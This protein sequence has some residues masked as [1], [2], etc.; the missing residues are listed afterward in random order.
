[1]TRSHVYLPY[2]EFVEAD[3]V[4]VPYRIWNSLEEDLPTSG[5]VNLLRRE[6]WVPLEWGGRAVT[7]HELAHVAWS[8]ARSA[9]VRFDHRVLAAMEDAR[10]N[11]GLAGIG[12]PVALDAESHAHVMMLLAQ[13][14]KR[15]DGFALFMRSIASLGTSVEAGLESQ[16]L[17]MPGPLGALVVAWMARA[18]RELEAAR[19]AARGPVAPYKKAVDLARALARELRALGLLDRRDQSGSTVQIGCWV[20]GHGRGQLEDPRGRRPH[21]GRGDA[22][23]DER[24]ES[25]P[26]RM[27]VKEVP[28]S[29][30]LRP[31]RGGLAW[32]AASEGSI[33]RYLSRWPVDGA[34]FRRRSRSGG[35][36]VL[37]DVSGS[38]SLD[39]GDLDRLLLATPQGARVAI[40]SGSGEVGE[41][42]IVANGGRRAAARHLERFGNGNIVDLPALEWLARQP[43][44]RLWISDGAVTG[45][46][47]RGSRAL[48]QRCDAVCKRS[49]IRRVAKLDEAAALLK[50]GGVASASGEPD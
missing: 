47:D 32:R 37:V 7:R 30:A 25:E 24:G 1:M 48:K 38:M 5:M 36:T 11:L 45:V 19:H 34:V 4:D 29:V 17:G 28:L 31:G 23:E 21:R 46:R 3:R 33:V 16:L 22:G 18:R 10:I 43:L 2:P 9:R 35:G 12:I 27:H 20:H 40:Y 15:G 50:S 8:P 41:L 6:M 44:P 14:A 26:G 49:R 13:D 42:R 39:A